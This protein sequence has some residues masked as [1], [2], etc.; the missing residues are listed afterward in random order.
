MKRQH[1]KKFGRK[2]LTTMK[3][4]L[5]GTASFNEEELFYLNRIIFRL[6]KKKGF[7]L[8]FDKFIQDITTL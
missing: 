7:R 3:E 1:L 4:A 2:A 6:L 8:R 5:E